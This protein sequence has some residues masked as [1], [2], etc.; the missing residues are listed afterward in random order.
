MLISSKQ[1]IERGI[2]IPSEYSKL[3]QVGVDLSVVKIEEIISDSLYASTVLVDKTYIDQ[4]SFIDIPLVTLP[5]DVG[6]KQVW[7]LGEGVYSVTFNEGCKI[8]S[9]L[10]GFI[11]QRSSLYRTGNQIMSPVW[12]PGYE[13]TQMGTTLIVN[14]PTIIELN[15]RLAQIIFH[16]NH[17]VDELYNGQW[18]NFTSAHTK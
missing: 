10:T 17:E 8:P 11:L 13:T 15:A 7:V 6:S 4:T 18:Q 9:N 14:N 3:T 1:I 2:I 16:E 12:D 5:L